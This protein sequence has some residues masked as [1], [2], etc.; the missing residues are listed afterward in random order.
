M[1]YSYFATYDPFNQLQQQQQQPTSEHQPLTDSRSPIFCDTATLFG[2][3]QQHAGRYSYEYDAG[4]PLD[5]RDPDS[6]LFPIS[7]NLPGDPVAASRDHV[8]LPSSTHEEDGACRRIRTDV[9]GLPSLIAADFTGDR[10]IGSG[11]ASFYDQQQQL[12]D[13]NCSESDQYRYTVD[14]LHQPTPLDGGG[15]GDD[16]M[17]GCVIPT[18]AVSASTSR[19]SSV[20]AYSKS[21]GRLA[22][23]SAT[24]AA[25]E[26]DDDDYRSAFVGYRRTAAFESSTTSGLAE[27]HQSMLADD[28]APSSGLLRHLGCGTAAASALTLLHQSPSQFNRRADDT[29]TQLLPHVSSSYHQFPNYVTPTDD[30]LVQATLFQGYRVDGGSPFLPRAAATTDIHVKPELMCELG[31]ENDE[32]AIPGSR[33]VRQECVA[34]STDWQYSAMSASAPCADDVLPVAKRTI[35][36]HSTRCRSAGSSTSFEHSSEAVNKQRYYF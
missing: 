4:L 3:F 20:S 31:N 2:A 26:D 1:N 27:D 8:G 13:R 33:R 21:T 12:G 7:L 11:P 30:Q 18:T 29:L 24:V 35:P 14:Q 10:G 36:S 9:A 34:S 15:G 25:D 23:G 19:S 5:A 32:I 16:A 17:T 28:D 6:G 22:S